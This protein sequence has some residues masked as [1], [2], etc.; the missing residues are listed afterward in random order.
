M[1]ELA[2][3]KVSNICN[4]YRWQI[5]GHRSWQLAEESLEPL[6]AGYHVLAGNWHQ[7]ESKGV[8][9]EKVLESFVKY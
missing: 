6:A 4:I 9:N 1:L 8:N 7:T 5:G 2:A 3:Q